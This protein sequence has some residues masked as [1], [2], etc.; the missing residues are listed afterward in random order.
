M[1]K[2]LTI[3]QF[4]KISPF[5][6]LEDGQFRRKSDG[7]LINRFKPEQLKVLIDILAIHKRSEIYEVIRNLEK[8]HYPQ[9][10]EEYI[11][12]KKLQNNQSYARTK[13][14]TYNK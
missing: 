3:E 12:I 5:E 13:G 9:K 2:K 6:K 11:K 14:K 4:L 10:Y 7:A 8:K 1:T